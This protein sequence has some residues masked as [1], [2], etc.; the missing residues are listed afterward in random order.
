MRLASYVYYVDI[1][2]SGIMSNIFLSVK[3]VAICLACVRKML[4]INDNV[5]V[6]LVY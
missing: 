2:L 1:V 3:Y 6:C 4:S 5:A